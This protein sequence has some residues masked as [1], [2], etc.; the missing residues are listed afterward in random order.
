MEGR[1]YSGLVAPQREESVI[2]TLRKH[3]STHQGWWLEDELVPMPHKQETER[4]I[5]NRSQTPPPVMYVLQPVLLFQRTQIRFQHPFGGS[6]S[7]V[8]PFQGIEWPLFA[9]K[10]TKHAHG[11]HT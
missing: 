8:T 5:S 11:I 3:G 10:C 7:P 4:V 1:G 2:I 6:E 9:C